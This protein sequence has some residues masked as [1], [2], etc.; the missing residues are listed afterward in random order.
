M[1]GAP[2]ASIIDGLTDHTAHHRG[3]LAVYARL[4]GKT[5]PMPYA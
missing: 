5:P 2:R 1:G 3:S 4:R